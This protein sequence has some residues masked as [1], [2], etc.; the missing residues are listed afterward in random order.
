MND[1]KYLRDR[2]FLIGCAAYATNRW[3]V[4]PHFHQVFLRSWFNDLLLIPCALPP[5]LFMHRYLK[6]RK[7]N[8][9]P[10]AAEVALHLVFWSALFEWWGPH[11]FRHATG[12]WFDV[13]AYTAGAVVAWLWWNRLA[14]AG[15]FRPHEL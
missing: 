5:I 3:V 4:K 2:L 9:P 13:A 8:E 1:F 6:L 7:H 12:D 11:L 14:V 10:T 15:L